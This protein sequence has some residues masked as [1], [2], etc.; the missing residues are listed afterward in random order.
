[1]RF[2]SGPARDICLDFGFFK[3][4]FFGCV[5]FQRSKNSSSSGKAHIPS[6]KPLVVRAINV[7]FFLYYSYFY[8]LSSSI[9]SCVVS[10][11]TVTVNG[12]LE[13]K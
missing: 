8:T 2:A 13:M 11:L 5:V 3:A 1:M 7:V 6:L 9:S 12:A 4:C 10:T